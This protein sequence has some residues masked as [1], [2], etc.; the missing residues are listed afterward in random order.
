MDKKPLKISFLE[1]K[2]KCFKKEF[3]ELYK[4]KYITLTLRDYGFEKLRNTRQKDIDNALKLSKKYSAKLIIIPD[5]IDLI[6]KYQIPNSV[7]VIKS[8]RE[9]I[10]IRIGIYSKSIVNIFTTSGPCILPL[11]IKGSKMIVI[12]AAC[13]SDGDNINYYKN[14][15]GIEEGDQP[16][17]RLGGYYLWNDLFKNIDENTLDFAYKKINQHKQD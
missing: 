15:L 12:R 11:F 13:G 7:K 4:S 6:N 5:N 1:V 9:D 16:F 14:I 3:I 8:A 10:Y 2:S 17:L